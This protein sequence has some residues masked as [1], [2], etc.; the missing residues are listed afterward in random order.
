MITRSA[1]LS[2]AR[3]ALREA[4]VEGGDA[5]ARVLVGA[6][7]GISSSQ[8]I[9]RGEDAVAEEAAATVRDWITR[10][11]AGEPV[12][13]L[14]GMREFWGLPFRLSPAT[15]V[16]RP[17]TETLVEAVVTAR[18]DRNAH[19]R[20][21]DLGTGSGCILLALL[22]EYWESTGVGIDLS[23]E[24]VDTARS[25][26]QM[27][28]M[29][30]RA[31][32]QQGS[33]DEG[34]TERFDVIVSNPPYIPS[35]DIEELEVEVRA[36]DP[37]LA[38]DGGDDGLTAYRALAALLPRRLAPG[39]LAALEIGI[40]QEKDVGRLMDEAGFTVTQHADLSGVIRVLKLSRAV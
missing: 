32:F 30:E 14:T 37:R 17:D 22:S 9:S 5:D 20:I 24:A 15:L 27:L 28:D 34:L 12:A 40:G 38:L 7:L 10:R 2:Q 19:L 11:M 26:A 36:H 35:P 13:R 21:L 23:A 29:E 8:L 39:G 1:L 16:P 31:F 18:R 6:A 25:N 3:A 4:G 33:W